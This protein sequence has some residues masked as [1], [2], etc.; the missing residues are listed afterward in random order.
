MENTPPSPPLQSSGLADGHMTSNSMPVTVENI[1][2]LDAVPAVLTCED[3]EQSILSEMTESSSTLQPPVQGLS[4]SGAK[5]EQLKTDIDDHASQHLLSLLQKGTNLSTGLDIVSSDTKQNMEVENL[6]TMLS[7]S[8]ERDTENTPNAGKLLTLETL[9]GTAFMKEL[10]PV[11]M[12]TSGQSGSVGSVK[13]SVLESPFPMTDDNF[14][15]SAD[16]MTIS[17]SSNGGI[18]A[19]H[20][21]QQLKPESVQEQILRFDHKNEVNLSQRQIDMGS[22]LG[23]FD[24]SVDIRL[25]EE[26][27]LI[28]SDPLN[29]QNF[30]HARSSSKAELSSM[31]ETAVDIAEKLTALN[32]VYPDERSIIG[33][34]GGASFFRGPYDMRE[35][36]VQYPNIQ[37]QPSS[38]QLHRPQFNHAGPMFH[39]LDSHPSNVNTQM[40]FMAPDNIHLD[41]PNNQFAANLLSPPFHHPSTGLTRLDPNPH[42]P[43][44]QQMHMP[45]NFPPPHLLR[46]FPRGAPLPPHPSNQVPGVIQESNPMQG[47]PFGQRQA[48]FGALGIPSQGKALYTHFASDQCNL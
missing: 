13:V 44:L 1:D 20:Q 34:Q 40:K 10:Q 23:G 37:A 14:H 7:S 11:G 19:S 9:F 2:K 35:S 22:K 48:N 17:M 18:L 26:D 36:D 6:S 16:D 15:T 39:A 25:P 5:T 38:P 31:P 42:N 30:M 43:M 45:G 12:P 32:S 33:G 8:R 28:T 3:L 41:P 4:G 24:G 21:R 47:F 29:L 27:S 46:G